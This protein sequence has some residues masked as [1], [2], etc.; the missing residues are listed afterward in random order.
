MAAF[1]TTLLLKFRVETLGI[2][3]AP[4]GQVVRFACGPPDVGTTVKL[5][6]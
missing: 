3:A 6:E 1:A 2:P 5:N 4:V